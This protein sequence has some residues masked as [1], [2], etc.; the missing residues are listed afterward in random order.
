MDVTEDELDKAG[1]VAGPKCR[2]NQCEKLKNIEDKWILRMGTFYGE[3]PLNTRDEIQA[4]T[5]YNWGGGGH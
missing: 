1:H 5:R 3:G 4:K 2:C